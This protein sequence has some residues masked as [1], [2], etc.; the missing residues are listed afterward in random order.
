MKKLLII[1]SLLVY[2]SLAGAPPIKR[3]AIILKSEAI[4]PYE[5]IW[6]AIIEV[7]SNGNQWAYNPKE[8]ATG[9]AQVREIRLR[10]YEIQQVFITT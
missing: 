2:S 8:K 1:L 7:E 3:D 5:R 6:Q 4:K 9:I 10:D